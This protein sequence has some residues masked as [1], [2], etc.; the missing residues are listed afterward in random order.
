MRPEMQEAWSLIR[1]RVKQKVSGR[2]LYRALDALQLV[3]IEGETVVLGLPHE[4]YSLAGHLNA[5]TVR[6]AL[7]ECIQ[8]A[9]AFRPRLVIIDGTTLHDWHLYQRKLEELRRLS[10]QGIRRREVESRALADWDAVYEQVGR[11]FAETHGRSLAI[12][13]ARYLNEALALVREAMR[14]LPLETDA[15]ERQLNRIVERIA[16][17]A[18]VPSA[19]VAWLLLYG[20]P[21]HSHESDQAS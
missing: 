15:D 4:E 18:E 3:T 5:P 21:S 1:E 11:K 20:A 8:E 13:R 2:T 17:H 12:N 9:Y 19:L 14:R 16:T 10:E 6:R 7:E